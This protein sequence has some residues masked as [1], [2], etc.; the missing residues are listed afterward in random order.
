M[1]KAVILTVPDPDSMYRSQEIRANGKFV[2]TPVKAIDY[3]RVLTSIG[4]KSSTSYVHELYHSMSKKRI[5]DHINGVKRDANYALNS[6]IR[7]FKDHSAI[8]M[9][10]LKYNGKS[11]PESSEIEYLTD[12]SY[13]NSD[14]TPIPMISDFLEKITTTNKKRQKI[15]NERK[16]KAGL[17]YISDAIEIINQHNHKPIMGYIPDYRPYIPRL[18]DLYR[19]AGI[20]TFYFDANGANPITVRSTIRALRKVL[21]QYDMLDESFLYMVNASYGRGEKDGMIP[22]RNILGFGLGIDGLGENHLPLRPP[23]DLT[24]KMGNRVRP[25]NLF[26]RDRYAYYRF[27]GKVGARL[28]PR[29]S[30]VKAKEFLVRERAYG[31]AENTFNVEQLVLESEHLGNIIRNSESMTKYLEDKSLDRKYIELLTRDGIRD[32]Q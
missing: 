27:N 19:D 2:K 3:D 7:R 18:V 20:N 6:C 31:K 1:T 9:C 21:V 13:V 14:I 28:Y 8:Q 11:F 26:L 29:D 23:K 10:F 16:F 12:L 22:A 5:T 4:I 30:G 24:A 15:P 17:R 32:T 25:P